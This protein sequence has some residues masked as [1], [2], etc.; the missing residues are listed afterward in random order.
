MPGLGAGK[1]RLRV[2]GGLT[3][4]YCH[5]PRTGYRDGLGWSRIR[6][7]ATL[8]EPLR[9]GW[10]QVSAARGLLSAA[11]HH[12]PEG[13]PVPACGLVTPLAGSGPRSVP[14]SADRLGGVP[15]ARL[16]NPPAQAWPTGALPESGPAMAMGGASAGRRRQGAGGARATFQ[17]DTSI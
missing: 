1:G 4:H 10:S 14:A 7:E 5:Y 3:Y 8:S 13:P 17:A 15:A 6:V 2:P 11:G 16:A 12:L 9:W